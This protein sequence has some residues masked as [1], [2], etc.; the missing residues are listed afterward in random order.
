[1]LM[2][3]AND[4]S[5]IDKRLLAISISVSYDMGWQKRPTGRIYD[6]L[7]GH[8]F[9]IGCLTGNVIMMGIMKKNLNADVILKLF[10]ICALSIGTVALVLWNPRWR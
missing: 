10:H 8:G 5:K 6:S 7:S 9:F 3:S 1:M 2:M 4:I